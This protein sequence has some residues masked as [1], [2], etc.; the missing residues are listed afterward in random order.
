M[1]SILLDSSV[2]FDSLN[3]RREYLTALIREGH[4]LACCPINIAEVYSGLRDH[5]KQATEAFLR[6]LQ[7]YPFTAEVAKEAGLLQ[8]EWRLK[9]RTLCFTDVSIAAIAIHN[10]TPLLIDNRKD[11]PMP[12]LQLYPLRGDNGLALLEADNA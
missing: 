2:I 11:F 9:G 4:L 6:S 10:G 8:R 12:E 3:G 1:F 5:E 7:F